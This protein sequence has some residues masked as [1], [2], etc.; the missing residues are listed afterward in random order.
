MDNKAKI[1]STPRAIKGVKWTLIQHGF[2]TTFF[3]LN[4]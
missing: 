3:I 4:T 2:L 1:R